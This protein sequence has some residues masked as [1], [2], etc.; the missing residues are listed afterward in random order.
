MPDEKVVESSARYFKHPG[1]K[2]L[3]IFFQYVLGPAATAAV[4]AYGL[5]AVEISKQVRSDVNDEIDRREDAELIVARATSVAPVQTESAAAA[6]DPAR[7]P[8]PMVRGLS[9]SPDKVEDLVDRLRESPAPTTDSDE[10]SLQPQ[11]QGD[12]PQELQDEWRRIRADNPD[13]DQLRRAA[14]RVQEQT[15]VQMQTD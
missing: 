1:W 14:N 12:I 8:L 5:Y 4:T 15:Q 13:I 3:A 6:G 7:R 2:L 11:W 9:V 10:V